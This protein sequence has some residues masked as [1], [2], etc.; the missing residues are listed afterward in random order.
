MTGPAL[1]GGLG[2]PPP[3]PVE[4]GRATMGLALGEAPFLALAARAARAVD[5]VTNWALPSPRA[6]AEVAGTGAGVAALDWPGPAPQA[7]TAANAAIATMPTASRFRPAPGGN[8]ANLN[9]LTCSC[10]VGLA[11]AP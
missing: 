8:I 6:P 9:N 2:T 10:H 1:R 11:T 7:L 3:G 4:C 5:L